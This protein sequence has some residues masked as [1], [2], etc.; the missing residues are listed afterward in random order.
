MFEME[1]FF[2]FGIRLILLFTF[3]VFFGEIQ[4]IGQEKQ[5]KDFCG[6]SI[7][8]KGK[9]MRFFTKKIAVDLN[10]S[11][12]KWDEIV[13]Q[14]VVLI[15]EQTMMSMWEVQVDKK[16]HLEIVLIDSIG[17]RHIFDTSFCKEYGYWLLSVG[18]GDNLKDTI[19]NL[20]YSVKD[21]EAFFDMIINKAGD[22]EKG[23]LL[24]DFR[25]TKNGIKASFDSINND[26]KEKAN[27]AQKAVVVYL[28]GH[29]RKEKGK[30]SF[31]VK[32]EDGID[33]DW[34]DENTLAKWI[35]SL[36]KDNNLVVWFFVDTCE[37]IDLYKLSENNNCFSQL[38]GSIIRYSSQI[39]CD[40]DNPLYYNGN[41]VKHKK[42]TNANYVI[43]TLGEDRRKLTGKAIDGLFEHLFQQAIS[44]LPIEESLLTNKLDEC[45][46]GHIGER[47]PIH[48]LEEDLWFPG[49]ITKEGFDKQHKVGQRPSHYLDVAIGYNC[50]NQLDFQIGLSWRSWSFFAEFSGY[51]DWTDSITYQ[52]NNNEPLGNG[53][54]KMPSKSIFGIGLGV[55]WYPIK[56]FDYFGIGFSSQVGGAYGKMIVTDNV[57]MDNPE[58]DQYILDLREK[59]GWRNYVCVT[60]SIAVRIPAFNKFPCRLHI[61][62]GYSVY[63]SRYEKIRLMNREMEK[64]PIV[65]N[66]GLLIPI[67]GNLK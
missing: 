28:S 48:L 53:M 30:Y 26:I 2:I 43:D 54:V 38:T 12:Y 63:F 44:E 56:D 58:N 52:V 27:I 18:T 36:V 66:A 21:A 45:F 13:K 3:F 8:N 17:N 39:K 41:D 15:R 10:K 25:A 35:C 37:S 59:Q 24:N 6:F 50:D 20:D 67:G 16:K 40:N 32:N 62:M 22:P 11:Y 19:D 64:A 47:K 5:D 46:D 42:C 14:P 57:T 61:N 4:S 1:K 49:Q 31:L 60:P 55:M 9:C 23:I 7:A 65:F 51:W 34:V 29:G 33:A